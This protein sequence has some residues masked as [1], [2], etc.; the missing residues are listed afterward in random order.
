[1]EIEKRLSSAKKAL[2]E[3]R[4]LDKI[5]E[6]L[7][8]FS[9]ALEATQIQLRKEFV[10]SV[11]YTMNE[12]WPNLYPYQDFSQMQIAVED[13]DYVL[14]LQDRSGKW[15][16]VDGFASGGERSIASLSLRI[17]FALVL[18][19]QLKWLVLDEPTA[20]MDAKAVED[21]AVTLGERIGDFIE[22]TFLITHDEKLEGAVTGYA[23]KLQRDKSKDEPTKVIAL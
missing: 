18:A 12:L 20:N 13:G 4:E 3:M 11:N 1:V 9:K 22:Q 16:N 8:V 15:N 6:D 17:S 14:Q 5:I 19:P 7:K 10:A 21:L 23:Y 2:D